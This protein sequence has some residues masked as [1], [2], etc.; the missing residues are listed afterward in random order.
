MIASGASDHL[1]ILAIAASLAQPMPAGE[2]I[3]G[4]PP[5]TMHTLAAALNPPV[6]TEGRITWVPKR[7]VSPP[8]GLASAETAPRQP[9]ERGAPPFS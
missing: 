1:G 3:V 5:L 7:K 8:D 9:P 2:T 4:Q 6:A